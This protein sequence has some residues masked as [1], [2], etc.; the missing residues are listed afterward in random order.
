M[1][2]IQSENFK[3]FLHKFNK[4]HNGFVSKLYNLLNK[5]K[6]LSPLI[7]FEIIIFIFLHFIFCVENICPFVDVFVSIFPKVQ[8]HLSGLS[9]TVT[10]LQQLQKQRTELQDWIK[11]QDAIVS[12]WASRPC[13]LRPEAAKQELITMNDLLNNIGDKRSQLMTEMTGS[14]KFPRRKYQS[15]SSTNHLT[16][17]FIHTVADDD[18]TD[19]EQQL[20]QLE[21]D[22]MDAIASKST[23]QNIIDNYRKSVADMNTWFD[24]VIKKIDVIDIGSGLNCAQKLAAISEIQNEFEDQGPKKLADLK[25]KAQKVT[26]VISNLDAQQVE[27]QLK[28]VDRRYNDIS[29]RIDRKKQ[30]LEATNK[31]IEC[32]R[33]EIEQVDN[34]SKQQIVN[35]QAPQSIGL[36]SGF[37]EERLQK[38]KALAKETESKIALAETLGR[39]VANMQNDLEPL[40]QSQLEGELRDVEAKQ[41]ELIDLLK[42]EVASV[43]DAA[44]ARKKFEGDVENAKQWIKTKAIEVKKAPTQLPLLSTALENEIQTSKASESDIKKFGEALIGEVQKQAQAVIKDCPEPDKAQIATILEELEVE[45]GTVKDEV[46]NKTTSL[47]DLLDARKAF[48][49]DV[50]KLD[51]WLNEAEIITSAEIRTTSLP[52]LE[53]Q[54][55]KFESLNAENKSMNSL[56]AAVVDQAKSISPTLSGPDKMKLN[57]QVKALKDK[58]HKNTANLNERIR[59]TQDHIKRHN[60]A[61]DKLAKC[62]EILNKVQQEIQD[63]NKPIG[64]KVDDVKVLLSSYERLLNQLNDNKNKLSDIPIDNLPELQQIMLRQDDMIKLIENQLAYL[65]QL[66]MLREQFIA[67]IN[68]IVAFIMKYTTVIT[69]IE[70]SS[71][72]IEEKIRQYDDVI[73]KIQECEG[74]LASA[75]DKGEQI[76]A[77]GTAADRNAITEQLQSLKQQLQNLRKLVETQRKKHELT[78]AEHTKLADDLSELL[79][80][81]H[82]NEATCKS[83]PLLD[84]DTDLVEREINRHDSFAQEVQTYLD[85]I[86]KIDELTSNDYEMP[87]S[88]VEMVSEGRS[89]VATL[90]DELKDRRNYLVDAKQN[91]ITYIQ[92]VSQFKEWVNEAETR[93]DKSKHGVDYENLPAD[94][95]EHKNFFG[96]ETPIKELVHRK[97]QDAVDK[98]WST[99]NLAEQEELSHEVAQYKAT[100]K[101]ILDAAKRQRNELEENLANWKQYQQLLE[102]IKGVLSRAQ[103]TEE[104]VSNLAGLQFNLQKTMHALNDLKVSIERK[105]YLLLTL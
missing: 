33:N 80:W 48:E 77:E 16:F 35:L 30:M 76:A 61:K 13:K 64:T 50:T 74:L 58:Y 104:P 5:V 71:D 28:S 17:L 34:W 36:Q 49:N 26:E 93:L 1:D 87:A 55:A 45:L 6:M 20:D 39:R 42:A 18:N 70:K 91:R 2:E 40:E 66:L 68:Q 54:L 46:G 100:L 69:D 53:E 22:L 51:D 25:Q 41:K 9:T 37:A 4:N 101:T 8:C 31:G 96:N 43:S 103:V 99:L 10:E 38:L 12:D 90:P 82:D 11:K 59:T 60:D 75:S 84:R 56:L 44:L 14:C 95:E 72:S 79:D 23:G 97:I 89:L 32:A 73:S 88:L 27:E 47:N 3:F 81:L 62:V 94:I 92:L 57:E 83:R 67:L 15:L 21:S 86:R 7:S 24:N 102:K 52:I 65:R 29:K 98:I 85:K 78:L 63:L 19:I 105:D